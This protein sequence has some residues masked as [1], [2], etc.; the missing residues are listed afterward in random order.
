MGFTMVATDPPAQSSVGT[1][2]NDE[3]IG[4]ESEPNGAG[5]PL[6]GDFGEMWELGAVGGTSQRQPRL[7][8]EGTLA[9]KVGDVDDD[10]N[11]PAEIPV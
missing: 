7:M 6:H 2:A 1:T 11:H 3:F 4:S 10:L 9:I 8:P 5:R